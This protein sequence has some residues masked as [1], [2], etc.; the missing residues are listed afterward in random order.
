MPNGIPSHDT[1]SDVLGRIDPVA[2]RA[3]FTAWATAA[4]PGLAGE[5]V[6]VDG[7]AVRGSR[8]GVNPAVHLGRVHKI[9]LRVRNCWLLSTARGVEHGSFVLPYGRAI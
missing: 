7:K 3:A 6:C 8:N 5:Q 4:L 9:M 2:F 1:L